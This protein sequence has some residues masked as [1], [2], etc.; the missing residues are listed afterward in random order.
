MANHIL[1]TADAPPNP[2]ALLRN[3]AINHHPLNTA[4]APSHTLPPPP[5]AH[6]LQKEDF[7]GASD[8]AELQLGPAGKLVTQGDIFQ[9][10]SISIHS[11][12]ETM[13]LTCVEANKTVCS[14]AWVC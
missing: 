6:T 8:D 2:L 7:T 13:V 10:W 12:Y 3:A 11:N 14:V 1:T 9:S 4:W 5:P